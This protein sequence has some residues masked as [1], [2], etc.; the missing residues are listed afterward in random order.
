MQLLEVT[1]GDPAGDVALDEAL[2]EEAERGRGAEVLRLW[3]PRG[4][5]VVVGRSSRVSDEVDLNACGK[6]DIRLV[7]RSS[8]GAA[9][10]TGPGCLMY[11]LTLSLEHRLSLR[12]I[13]AAHRFVLETV[14]A[15]LA[16]HVP[17]VARRGTSDLAVGEHKFSGNSMRLKQ[18]WVLY[19]GT[20]LY[21]FPLDAIGRYLTLP[22]RRPAYR[23]DRSHGDF[24]QNLPLSRETI[25]QALVTA[26]EAREKQEEWPREA[27]AELVA[28]KHGQRSWNYAV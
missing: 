27:V 24:V 15:S 18:D 6:D 22:P 21:D 20:V 16:M 3:E 2:L 23:A 11:A 4:T 12:M 14:A 25:C 13:D 26:F 9:I 10:V 1:L 8:G 19:H 17:G 5:F 7:R 28:K